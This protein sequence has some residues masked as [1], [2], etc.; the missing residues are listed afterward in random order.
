MPVKLGRYSLLLLGLIAILY[1][2]SYLTL[3]PILLQKST[4]TK[5]KSFL[6]GVGVDK[7]L[8]RYLF[9]LP[10]SPFI[11][12]TQINSLGPPPQWC[13]SMPR[14]N[15]YIL[16][17]LRTALILWTTPAAEARLSVPREQGAYQLARR[18]PLMLTSLKVLSTDLVLKAHR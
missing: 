15:G 18:S 6:Y 8:F 5:L 7:F 17:H 1:L 4:S 9:L 3:G 2:V 11:C 12:L 14:L 10:W 16:S 13:W